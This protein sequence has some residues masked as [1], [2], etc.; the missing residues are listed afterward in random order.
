MQKYENDH[1]IREGFCAWQRLAAFERSSCEGN[2]LDDIL[3]N[4]LK[5][6]NRLRSVTVTPELWLKFMIDENAGNSSFTI[7]GCGPP[8][9]RNWDPSHA[10]PYP[11]PGTDHSISDFN[12]L[13]FTLANAAVKIRN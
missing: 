8:L 13:T 10:H 3:Y 9:L 4:G 1:F 11:V 2:Q 6:L 7:N 5:R 12:S